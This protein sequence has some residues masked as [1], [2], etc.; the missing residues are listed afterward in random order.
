V[1]ERRAAGRLR[2]EST[3]GINMARDACDLSLKRTV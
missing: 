1:K 2:R 3:V